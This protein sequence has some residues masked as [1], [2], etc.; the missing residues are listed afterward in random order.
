MEQ[1]ILRILFVNAS[2]G[3]VE[4]WRQVGQAGEVVGP[5]YLPVDNSTTDL[6]AYGSTTLQPD[7]LRG[8]RLFLPGGDGT[9]ALAAVTAGAEWW[10][11]GS[12]AIIMQLD[13]LETEEVRTGRMAALLDQLRSVSCCAEFLAPRNKV[14]PHSLEPLGEDG[15][16]YVEPS[17]GRRLRVVCARPSSKTASPGFKYLDVGDKAAKEVN[18]EDELSEEEY[19]FESAAPNRLPVIQPLPP[20]PQSRII[21][22]FEPR[23]PSNAATLGS[24][25]TKAGSPGDCISPG[26]LP[27]KK[28]GSRV[29]DEEELDDYEDEERVDTSTTDLTTSSPQPPASPQALAVLGQMSDM[30][31]EIT[32][33]STSKQDSGGG[34]SDIT[35]PC[36]PDPLAEDSCHPSPE[37]PH[38]TVCASPDPDSS[39][40]VD[41]VD[42]GDSLMVVG[43]NLGGM[44]NQGFSPD[45]EENEEGDCAEGSD[46]ETIAADDTDAGYG[47]NRDLLDTLD[48]IAPLPEPS[49]SP[50]TLPAAAPEQSSESLPLLFFLHGVGGSADI[51]SNQFSHFSKLGFTCVAPD[52]LG[53]GFSAC[54]DSSKAYTFSRLFKDVLAIFDAYVPE[55]RKAVVF[56]HSYG[57]S[58][59]V[60][61]ARTRPERVIT[62]ILVAGGGPTPL[63][64]PPN[65]QTKTGVKWVMA[66]LRRILECKARGSHQKYNP[67]GKSLRFREAYDVPNYVLQHVMAGQ[68]WP[69]GDAGFHRRV[70]MPT[71]LVYGMRDCL[72]S[73]VEECEMERTLPKSYLELV[74]GAGHAVMLD[75]PVILNTMTERFINKWTKNNRC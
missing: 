2:P 56:G 52:M 10:N 28:L 7:S 27:R 14:L 41:F 38:R 22:K 57:C 11:T 51:W 4:A 1:K 60:A 58:F 36:S 42:T 37:V 21:N 39:A 34:R 30:I 8:S 63:A 71:L 25:L 75:T 46:T 73:L 3:Q 40:P 74:P 59:S 72:V 18:S 43:G 12:L 45:D 26:R 29:L 50:T 20:P 54:P 61:L 33:D 16:Q 68:I 35:P 17:P 48:S 62:L 24:P 53:H 9:P 69:E 70:T 5:I 19:W 49:P 66:L 31:L 6:P 67:R 65:S 13:Q 47:R 15:V 55:E 64:P 44:A 23:E 32:A